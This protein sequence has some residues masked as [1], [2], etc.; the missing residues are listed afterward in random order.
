MDDLHEW[1][2]D[3]TFFLKFRGQWGKRPSFS[4][5]GW[6]EL[7]AWN[8]NILAS[9]SFLFTWQSRPLWK[10]G[11]AGWVGNSPLP[12]VL[13]CSSP[14]WEGQLMA[15]TLQ[16]A[17][18]GRHR[19][20]QLLP[21]PRLWAVLGHGHLFLRVEHGV[22]EFSIRRCFQSSADRSDFARLEGK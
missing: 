16:V 2:M 15:L 14:F 17:R 18:K 20:D 8:R 5:W 1:M 13:F 22:A 3:H 6:A 9:L 19:W 4:D 11:V 7:I 10:V 12:L 21:P